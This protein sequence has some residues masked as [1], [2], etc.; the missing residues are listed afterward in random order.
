[1]SQV[2]SVLDLGSNNVTD[3][4]KLPGSCRTLVLTGNPDVSFGAGAVEKA[5]KDI[6]FIDLRNATFG[7]LSDAL[8][9]IGQLAVITQCAL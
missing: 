5:I 9:L 6:V 2:L 7:N 8:L 1:L 4:A 3:V